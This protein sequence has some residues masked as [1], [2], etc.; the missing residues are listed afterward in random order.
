MEKFGGRPVAVGGVAG[1]GFR[2]DVKLSCAEGPNKLRRFVLAP[3][4]VSWTIAWRD[5]LKSQGS[6][7]FWIG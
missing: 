7:S 2:G 1:R 3:D 4:Y 5:R 6:A